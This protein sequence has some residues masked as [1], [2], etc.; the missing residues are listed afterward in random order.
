MNKLLDPRGV[1]PNR[2]FIRT[3]QSL[4]LLFFL[5]NWD[6]LKNKV[7]KALNNHGT[8]GVVDGNQIKGCDHFRF[9]QIS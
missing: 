5:K 8:T 4:E 2:L 7:L 3:A 6:F 9:V 1:D